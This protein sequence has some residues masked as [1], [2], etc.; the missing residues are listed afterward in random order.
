M[1]LIIITWRCTNIFIFLH[2]SKFN[3]V[4][5]TCWQKKSQCQNQTNKFTQVRATWVEYGVQQREMKWNGKKVK[6]VKRSFDERA[7]RFQFIASHQASENSGNHGKCR[8]RCVG[9]KMVGKLRK[10]E[11]FLSRSF[12]HCCSLMS[13]L[14]LTFSLTHTFDTHKHTHIWHTHLTRPQAC[15]ESSNL[16]ICSTQQTF[17]GIRR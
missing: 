12:S 11:R 7:M 1:L 2:E 4:W 8:S 9:K 15:V 13:S 14:A 16:K 5:A 3:K 10:K 6:K 17:Q